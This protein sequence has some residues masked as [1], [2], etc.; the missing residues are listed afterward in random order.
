ME[1]RKGLKGKEK[2]ISRTGRSPPLKVSL[3]N[4]VESECR[5]AE[6]TQDDCQARGSTERQVA[7]VADALEAARR[8]HV[9][10]DIGRE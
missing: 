4:T 2:V 3:P 9:P 1:G 6:D 10:V 8:G 7:F 5:D